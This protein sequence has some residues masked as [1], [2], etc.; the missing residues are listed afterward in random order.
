[1]RQ[2]QP[3]S[4]PKPVLKTGKSLVRSLQLRRTVREISRKHL[5]LQRLSNLLWA[6]DG[7]N[8]KNG[9]FA[10]LGR[11]AASAAP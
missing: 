3:N 9:P 6:A 2:L 5:S 10:M 4:L 1:M 8:R 7:V 11:T